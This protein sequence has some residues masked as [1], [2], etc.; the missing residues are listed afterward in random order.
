MLAYFK[1][2]VSH[3]LFILHGIKI[4]KTD[5][6]LY[7]VSGKTAP[8]STH[9]CGQLLRKLQIDKIINFSKNYIFAQS[10]LVIFCVINVSMTRGVYILKDFRLLVQK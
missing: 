1:H 2:A 4:L 10:I 6:N 7:T 3:L 9:V 8:S 5:V